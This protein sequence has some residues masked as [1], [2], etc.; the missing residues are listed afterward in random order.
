[1]IAPPRLIRTRL[2]TLKDVSREKFDVNKVPIDP[3]DCWRKIRGLLL[4]A[5]TDRHHSGPS[6]GDITASG[7]TSKATIS[8]GTSASGAISSGTAASST[9]AG[10]SDKKSETVFR[11]RPGLTMQTDSCPREDT[12][13]R[14]DVDNSNPKGS[15]QGTAAA[16]AAA[17]TPGDVAAGDAAAGDAAGGGNG[18]LVGVGSGGAGGVTSKAWGVGSDKKGGVRGNDNVS[19]SELEIYVDQCAWR[20]L[21]AASR[22]ASG[23]DCFFVVQ[24]TKHCRSIVVAAAATFN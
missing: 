15:E 1:M 14:D 23:G 6:N 21:H 19:K 4:Q 8:S 3:A 24:V 17:A 22:T 20:V 5:A 16:A 10:L 18:G 2:Q 12:S 7:A 11:S 9:T 13:W